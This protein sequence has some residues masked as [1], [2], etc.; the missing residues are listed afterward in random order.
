MWMPELVFYNTK[1]MSQATFQDDESFAT[2]ST[3]TCNYPYRLINLCETMVYLVAGHVAKFSV[4]SVHNLKN[5]RL[6][7]GKDWW[8]V[9]VQIHVCFLK[10]SILFQPYQSLQV[11]YCWLQMPIRYELLSFWHSEVSYC[12]CHERQ[13][14]LL[15]G[16]GQGWFG[17]PWSKRHDAICYQ[18][19]WIC[20]KRKYSQHF[21][22]IKLPFVP[23][24]VIEQHHHHWVQ[25]G[26]E[27]LKWDF[28]DNSA[29]YADNNGKVSSML[30]VWN[31]KY[32]LSLRFRSAPTILVLSTL[33]RLLQS[34]WLLFWS[35]LHSSSVSQ[36]G[37]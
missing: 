8:Y 36:Q 29:N 3:M 28:D 5:R 10:E 32:V 37:N 18:T 31:S 16:A 11:F 22:P 12:H 26:Q 20:W 13:H 35:W 1:E 6:F 24:E 7:K 30:F 15:C 27:D 25:I 17:E 19:H 9:S 33:K 14:W 4:D 23:I 2:K 21:L 34:T